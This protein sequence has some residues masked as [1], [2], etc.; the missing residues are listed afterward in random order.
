MSY[1]DGDDHREQAY[2][3]DSRIDALQNST[4][5]ARRIVGQRGEIHAF[6]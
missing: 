4:L 3:F 5:A 6:G 2:H 1:R